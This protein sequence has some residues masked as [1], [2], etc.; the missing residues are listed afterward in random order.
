MAN[1]WE[2]KQ[3]PRSADGVGPAY[4][5]REE[6]D[7]MPYEGDTNIVAELESIKETQTEI[8]K[9]LDD[10][11]DTRLTGS[12]VEYPS[13]YPDANAGEKLEAIEQTQESIIGELQTTNES[14]NNV[15]KY[16]KLQTNI[17]TN[18]SSKDNAIYTS[19]VEEYKLETILDGEVLETNEQKIFYLDATN[20][21]GIYLFISVDKPNWT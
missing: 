2:S 6:N 14:L 16:D 13:D 11:L 5:N 19:S 3:L 17:K 1:E 18:E 9:R 7:W 4:W 8:L 15:I 12:N 10:P 21:K 20:E